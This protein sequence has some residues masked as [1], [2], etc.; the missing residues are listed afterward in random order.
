MTVALEKYPPAGFR[1]A[2][3]QIEPDFSRQAFCIQGLLCD[4]VSIEQAKQK[5]VTCMRE[6]RRCNLVTPNANFLRLIRSDPGFRDA[7]LASDLSVIDGMPLVWLARALGVAVPDRVCGSDLCAALM[8]DTTGPFRAFFFGATDEIGHHVRKRLDGAATGLQ[9]AGVYAPGFGSI[10]G[11]SDPAVLDRINRAQPDLLVVSIGARKG[12]LWLT[13]NEHLVST[14][15]ICNLGATINFIAGTVK[16]APAAFRRYGLEWLWRMKEEPALWSRYALDL[17]TLVSVLLTQVLPCV[18]QRALHRPS[19]GRLAAAQLRHHRSGTTE[20]LRFDGAW[21]SRNLAEVR[22]ALTAATRTGRS[23]LIDLDRVTFADAA[24]MGQLLLAYGYQRR[25]Q[26]G[27]AVRASGRRI[28]N[29]L[30]RHGCGYLAVEA[31]ARAV[32]SRHRI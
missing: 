20:V 28:S 31:P 29:L 25:M 15:L 7:A 4:V 8:A 12:V 21:T 26:R 2:P 3:S 6:G 23:L 10:D 9:L 11:M 24:F 32:P 30:R 19:P 17:A 13:R 5:L 16:R 22:A 14:P 1:D 27:F 18:V